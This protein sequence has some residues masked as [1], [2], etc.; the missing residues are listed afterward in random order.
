MLWL[1]WCCMLVFLQLFEDV[2]WHGDVKSV[3]NII[4]SEAY[5]TVEVTIP[6]HGELIFLFD[7]LD[8]VFNVFLT[9]VFYAEVI[10]HKGK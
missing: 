5:A 9:R 3:C 2:S 10:H 4:Q 1:C 7:A 6:I 8:Q